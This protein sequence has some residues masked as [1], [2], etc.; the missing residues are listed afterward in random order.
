MV[1][2]VFSQQGPWFKYTIWLEFIV[3]PCQCEFSRDASAVIGISLSG[4]STLDVG[5]NA[6]ISGCLPLCVSPKTGWQLSAYGGQ[7][8]LQPPT[9]NPEM[10]KQRR[11]DSWEN[12]M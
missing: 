11:L 4:D 12:T 2:T 8:R 10:D 3:S 6:S 1:S 7:D 5:V 9:R